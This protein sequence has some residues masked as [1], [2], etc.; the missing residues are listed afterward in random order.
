MTTATTATATAA[1]RFVRADGPDKVTGS[2]RY[3]A[4]LSMTGVLAAK[5]RYAQVSHA[6]ITKLDVTAARAIPGVF[7]VLTADDVPNVRFGPMVQDRTLFARD[8]VRFEGE[9]VA[10][11]AAI[12][13]DTAQRAV[14]AIVVEYSP[15]PIVNDVE[16]ALAADAPLV[17]ENW[18]DYGADG[19][20][21]RERNDASFSSIAK[22]DVERGFAEADYIVRSH[23][24][25]D[26]CHAA[27]IEPR[28]V[29]AQWEGNKVTIWTSTQVP[30]DARAGVCE[31]LELPNN[32]VRI[33]VP[34]LGGGFG[35]K[36]GFHYE[37]HIAALAR[38]AKRPVR[39]VFSRREEFLA[40]DKRREGVVYDFETGVKANGTITARKVR[41]V[42][43]NGAYTSDAGFFSQLAAMHSLGPYKIPN[44]L[45]EAH[46]AYTNH[47]PSGSVRAP[48]APQ[49]C[50][51]L[52]SHTDEIA[53]KLGMD[54]VAFRKHN[55]VDTGDEGP[56]GQVYGEI[57]VQRCIDA[58]TAA[59]GYG[60]PLADGEAIGVAIGWWPSFASASGAYIKLDGDGSGQ[61]ITGAQECGTGAVMTLRQ[62]A[63]D[64]L[65]MQPE[66]FELVYQDTSAA[67]YDMGATGSQTL[68]NNGRAVIAAAGQIAAQLRELAANKLEAAAAD[69][70]LA[71]GRAHVA[72]SPDRGVAISK[73][74]G[75]AAGGELLI[76][77]GSGTP[78]PQPQLAGSTCVGDIGMAAWRAPQFSCHAV[79]LKLDRDTGVVRV[80]HVSTAHDS[81]TII[82]QIGAQGQVEGGVMMGIGQALTEGT[83]YDDHARQRNAALL[84][85]KLQTCAD[86]P[87]IDIHFVE[88]NTPNAGPHGA[89][90]LAEA[91][92][93]ATAAA[94][95]NGIAKLVGSPV[96]RL[97]MTAE[98]VWETLQSVPS[99]NGSSS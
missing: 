84:E 41:L 29:V 72:G 8:I 51:A 97:P 81:G 67:P 59:V 30:F 47:Q 4:D 75:A 56:S 79:R 43:D 54:P 74:A 37:A 52:E 17:H 22:G 23:Y 87:P 39:L 18:A 13:A 14:D 65:G 25:S 68:F 20:M 34:H 76:G 80:L 60:E 61:I 49:T 7:A 92:N 77:H 48:T 45:A 31:T 21:V 53:K 91:P 24:E 70:V 26:G 78:P 90:G 6:R 50:W 55:A 33:I 5:F 82:N 40:P 36:C 94:I 83:K 66:D 57:G 95:A 16:S 11:V 89:K 98:R 12:D 2:G 9:V 15:L 62:L 27:P 96:R 38:V 35:G 86:A 73:L 64:E 88:I 19:A 63:A 46:L 3:T 85:Y 28:A 10:A 69:I 32:R 99:N 42:I 58:A 93:V 1:K 44:V 71:D